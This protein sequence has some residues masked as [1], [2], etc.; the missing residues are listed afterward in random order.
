MTE[1]EITETK[2]GLDPSFHIDS[3]ESANWLL[4]ILGNLDAE[5]KRIKAQYEKRKAQIAREREGLMYRFGAEMEEFAR[6]NLT[7]KRKSITLLQGTVGF[8]SYPAS[9]KVEDINV[10]S[11]MASQMG[12]MVP[13]IAAYEKIAFKTFQENGEIMDGIKFTPAGTRLYFSFAKEE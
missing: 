9:C 6:Q 2:E 11:E 7:G 5:E 8:R 12:M 4:R 1:E 3:E 13:D 10:A